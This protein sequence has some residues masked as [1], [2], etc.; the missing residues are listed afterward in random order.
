MYNNPITAVVIVINSV[1]VYLNVKEYSSSG[2]TV[3][4]VFIVVNLALI[5]WFMLGVS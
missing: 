5:A 3:N 2:R 4:L 1:A